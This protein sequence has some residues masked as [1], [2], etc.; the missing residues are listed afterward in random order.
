MFFSLEAKDIM[1]SKLLCI[2]PHSSVQH[3]IT[4]LKETNHNSFPVVTPDNVKGDKEEL[5]VIEQ[6]PTGIASEN[7]RFRVG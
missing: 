7:L 2:L 5:D 6:L 3:V 1:S 4:L